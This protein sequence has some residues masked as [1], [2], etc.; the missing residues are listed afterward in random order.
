MWAVHSVCFYLK[1]DTFLLCVLAFG[2]TELLWELNILIKDTNT[3]FK[4][5]KSTDFK[6]QVFQQEQAETQSETPES[7]DAG[8]F[9]SSVT[10]SESY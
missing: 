7:R 4:R 6:I 5:R 9:V 2:F 10:K 8:S 3:Y 1:Q